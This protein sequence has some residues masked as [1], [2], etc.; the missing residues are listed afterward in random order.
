MS[1]GVRDLRLLISQSRQAHTD[2]GSEDEQAANDDSRCQ[3]TNA[4]STHTGQ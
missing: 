1:R 2:G 4:L 3:A